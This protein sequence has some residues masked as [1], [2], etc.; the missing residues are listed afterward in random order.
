M[1]PSFKVSVTT[2]KK[3]LSYLSIIVSYSTVLP[4]LDSILV[5]LQEDGRVDFL[6][7][8]LESVSS[9][10][11]RASEFKGSGKFLMPFKKFLKFIHK[12]ADP[13]V[14]ITLVGDKVH[15]KSGP[16]K[17]KVLSD[18]VDNYPKP[19]VLDTT[20]WLISMKGEQLIT[21]FLKAIKFVSTDDLRPSMTGVFFGMLNE[22]FYIAATDAHAMYF[23]QPTV[24][25]PDEALNKQTIIPHKAIRF[26]NKFDPKEDVIISA[27]NNRICFSSGVFTIITRIIDFKYPD[28]TKVLPT[29]TDAFYMKRT[30]I[31]SLLLMSE[32]FMSSSRQVSLTVNEN[33]AKVSGGDIDFSLEFEF[34]MPVYEN[35]SKEDFVIGL[36]N[37]YL[38]KILGTT[39]DPNVK[40]EHA[41]RSAGALQIDS[42]FII[43]PLMLNN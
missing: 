30:Q 23:H 21:P 31:S 43:M 34:S 10:Y 22:R 2:V 5:D 4:I 41:H 39:K 20:S 15:L 26:V 12:S 37:K 28:F 38:K 1:N 24:S 6:V 13:E 27:D 36:D 35:T 29:Q 18:S 19:P 7:T 40:I 42:E 16:F 3:Q 32:D 17:A 33:S 9:F 14:E 25:L 11:I 8:D